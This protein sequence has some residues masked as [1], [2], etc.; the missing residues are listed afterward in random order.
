MGAHPDLAKLHA[1]WA[2]K[3]RRRR[4]TD[5]PSRALTSPTR[6]SAQAISGGGTTGSRSGPTRAVRPQSSLASAR[7]LEAPSSSGR[8]SRWTRTSG[9]TRTSCTSWRGQLRHPM[10]DRDDGLRSSQI[11]DQL[12]AVLPCVTDPRGLAGCSAPGFAQRAVVDR[13]ES[14]LVVQPRDKLN[15]F[16]VVASRPTTP[17]GQGRLE[18]GRR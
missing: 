17:T 12:F 5:R 4:P 7:A 18:G 1:T 8:Q 2:H 10:R 11:E 13:V 15:G 3:Y 9:A 6:R 16:G 14:E